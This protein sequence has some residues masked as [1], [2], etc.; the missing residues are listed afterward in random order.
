MTCPP[1]TSHLSY[2][3]PCRLGRSARAI[4]GVPETP[5]TAAFRACA[6][7]ANNP[8][9]GTSVDG[10]IGQFQHFGGM[11]VNERLFVA[12]L[13]QQFDGAIDAGD[14]QRAIELLIRVAMSDVGAAETVDAVLSNP[15]KYGYPR[16]S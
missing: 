16:P 2:E 3:V 5:S 10:V 8:T 11:T 7:D 14:R 6:A 4:G 12:G 15:A 1:H 9:L 13:L